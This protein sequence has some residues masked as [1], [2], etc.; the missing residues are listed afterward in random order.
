MTPGGIDRL[1]SGL[2]ECA[3]HIDEAKSVGCRHREEQL[4]TVDC[5]SLGAMGSERDER[6]FDVGVGAQLHV[7]SVVADLRL[8][9]GRCPMRNRAAV[10]EHHNVV[11]ETVRLFEVLSCEDHRATLPH[12]FAQHVPQVVATARVE[13][14]RRLIEEQHLRAAHQTGGEIE[15]AAHAARVRPHQRVGEIGQLEAGQQFVASCVGHMPRHAAQPSDG[16]EVEPR[17]HEPVNRGLLGGDPDSFA[18]RCGVGHDVEP[19]HVGGTFGRL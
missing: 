11:G 7:E 16:P 5:R 15:A 2:V 13:A 3:H 9:C 14:R 1:D 18:D 8:Q 6:W 10:V 17:A 12:K 19:G 4:V